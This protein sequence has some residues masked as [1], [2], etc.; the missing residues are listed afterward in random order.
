V[1]VDVP[2]LGPALGAGWSNLDVMD[3]GE[4]WLRTMLGLRLPAGDAVAAAAGWG[5]GQYRAW[6]DGPHTAVLLEMAW[7][8]PRDVGEFLG[9]VRRW[10]GGRGTATA[11][12]IGDPTKVVALFA[13]DP[14]TLAAL[15]GALA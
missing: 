6:T 4:L 3:A 11:G 9:A 12:T 2:D 10:I 7:D 5:G 8:T 13:S 15:R 1:P 14:A